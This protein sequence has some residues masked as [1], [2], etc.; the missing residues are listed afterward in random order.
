M[1]SCKYIGQNLGDEQR[2]AIAWIGGANERRAGGPIWSCGFIP[3]RKEENNN[4]FEVKTYF[5]Y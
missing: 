3:L 2:R 1:L 5:T 4:F